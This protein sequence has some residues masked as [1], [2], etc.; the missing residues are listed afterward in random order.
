[1]GKGEY[2]YK[3]FALVYSFGRQLVLKDKIFLD[4]GLRVAYTPL[5]NIFSA[6]QMNDPGTIEEHF[7][8]ETRSRIFREQLF[9]LHFGIG[10]LAF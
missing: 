10:F 1:M 3:N 2:N 8:N 9:N 6:I 4:Y 7:K 5:F